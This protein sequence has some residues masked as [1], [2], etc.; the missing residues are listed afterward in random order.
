M[1]DE[2]SNVVR[3]ENSNNP[4]NDE[5]LEILMER[6]SELKKAGE[7]TSE[8]RQKNV[9]LNKIILRKRVNINNN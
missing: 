4:L 3:H 6:L 5:P 9:E 1:V 8:I 2:N 7:I